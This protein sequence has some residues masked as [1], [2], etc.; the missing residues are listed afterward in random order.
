MLREENRNQN[1]QIARLQEK[2]GLQNEPNLPHHHQ[3]SAK[4]PEN[5]VEDL[6]HQPTSDDFHHHRQARP[7]RLLPIKHLYDHQNGDE[8]VNKDPHQLRRF[9]GQPTNC[10][11]LS[12]LGY[13]LNGFYLVKSA[14]NSLIDKLGQQLETV[15]CAFKQPDEG[16]FK[17]SG[18][19][20]RVGFLKLDISREPSSEVTTISLAN[21]DAKSSQSSSNNKIDKSSGKLIF[22]LQIRSTN[23]VQKTGD[24]VVFDNII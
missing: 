5:V 7:Y 10:S 16:P 24:P 19:E 1:I 2:V 14:A 18:L 8:G 6:S 15:F 12:L 9:Y 21:K 11:D 13:T 22:H 4:K 17:S 23:I 3:A 20:T